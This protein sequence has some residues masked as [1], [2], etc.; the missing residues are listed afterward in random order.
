ETATQVS[1]R[2]EIPPSSEP[3]PQ[4]SR[5]RGARLCPQDQPQQRPPA[6]RL[7][8]AATPHSYLTPGFSPEAFGFAP[9]KL[10]ISAPA[11]H[12]ISETLRLANAASN[13]REAFG[14]RELAPAFKPVRLT[15][16]V[17]N[18]LYLSSISNP[19][20]FLRCAFIFVPAFL[21]VLRAKQIS[22]KAE[23]IGQSGCR[24]V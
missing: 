6:D 14:L 21:R 7:I 9:G 11:R 15:R 23:N 22:E 1:P 19:A 3:R 8:F 20:F 5:S 13:P 17:P 16:N 10:E 18:S 2:P 24:T 4:T 12:R